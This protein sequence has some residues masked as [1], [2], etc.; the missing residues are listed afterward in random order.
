LTERI[1]IDGRGETIQEAIKEMWTRIQPLIERGYNP[2]SGV[3][4]IENSSKN[5]VQ[6]FQLSDP[7]F[8]LHLRND[9]T[10]SGPPTHK[11]N[12]PHAPESKEHYKYTARVELVS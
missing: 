9:M 5:I 2:V 11:M 10:S 12:D 4:V 3:Q 7:E 6:T 1:T 8:E